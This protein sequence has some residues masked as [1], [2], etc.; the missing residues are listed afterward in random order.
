MNHVAF[1]SLS[2]TEAQVIADHGFAALTADWHVQAQRRTFAGRAGPNEINFPDG[3][4]K[5]TLLASIGIH[6]EHADL[7]DIHCVLTTGEL[8]MAA[9]RFAQAH[10]AC[11]SNDAEDQTMDTLVEA[12]SEAVCAALAHYCTHV[13][14]T[15]N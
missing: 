14:I 3:Q 7:T 1:I 10:L 15:I 6:P 13:L 11:L 5:A 9:S 8:A 12:M 2:A 4:L